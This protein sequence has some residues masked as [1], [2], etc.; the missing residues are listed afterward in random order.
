M[1]KNDIPLL[2]RRGILLLGMRDIPLFR[3]RSYPRS[4][5]LID[6]LRIIACQRIDVV[7]AVGFKLSL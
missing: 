3:G 5:C 2:H 4:V 7:K 6:L 1:Y